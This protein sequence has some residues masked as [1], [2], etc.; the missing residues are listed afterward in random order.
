[1]LWPHAVNHQRKRTLAVGFGGTKLR[2]CPPQ[3]S[4]FHRLWPL[5]ISQPLSGHSVL[6]GM[7]LTANKGRRR[8]RD[9][10]DHPAGRARR[11]SR[12]DTGSW[13]L[14]NRPKKK[15]SSLQ[16]RKLWK[17]KKQQHHARSET[18]ASL[19]SPSHKPLSIPAARPKPSEVPHSAGPSLRSTADHPRIEMHVLP[20]RI[21]TL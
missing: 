14:L 12:V 15:S 3:V 13:A 4:I 11:R 8:H 5:F 2:H 19:G 17:R 6:T 1:M 18:T 10:A 9:F 21:G 16:L 7:L 20:C